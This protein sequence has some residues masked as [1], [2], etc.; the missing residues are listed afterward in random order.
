MY[1]SEIAT[2]AHK[3]LYVSW[4]SAS[5]QLAVVCNL[6][7]PARVVVVGAMTEAGEL[8]LGPIRTA[9]QRDI[10]PNEPPDLVLGT[11]GTRHTALGAIA[12]ALAETDWL[13]A[14]ARPA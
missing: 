2:P 8:V 10:A 12:L 7:A 6:L 1:L 14:A 5:Q 9:L 13:P 4:Q 11:L 3:G